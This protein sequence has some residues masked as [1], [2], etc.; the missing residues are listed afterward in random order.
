MAAKHD[1]A[2]VLSKELC[3]PLPG[4]QEWCSMCKNKSQGKSVVKRV[5]V[6]KKNR[7]PLAHNRLYPSL[8]Y[9]T[10]STRDIAK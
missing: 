7:I 3:I 5:Y 10:I 6:D 9:E 8:H 4:I 2:T 1:M